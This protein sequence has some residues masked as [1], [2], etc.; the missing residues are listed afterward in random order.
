VERT[1]VIA[2]AGVNHNGSAKLALQLVEVAA[3]CGAD[4]VKFQSFSADK[5]VRRGAAKAAYQEQAT[6]GGDQHSMLKA[7][8]M[9]EALHRDL[10]DRCGEVGIEFMS[11][12]FDEEAAAFLVGLGMR[13]LKVPS[14]EITN[15]P[16]LRFL[17]AKDRPLILST[18]MATLAEI[19]QAVE[20]IRGE[21]ARLG[22][23]GA[24]AEVLTVLHCTSNYPAAADD[25]NLRAMQT[26]ALATG[27]PV[28]YSDHTRGIAVSTAAVALGATV[29]EKHF[30]LDTGL[31]GPDHQASLSPP[32]LAE[33]IAQIRVVERALG[34]PVKEP[35]AAELPIRSLVRRSVT[36]RRDLAAGAILG[37]DDVCLLRPG[38]GI[39]PRDLEA[40]RGRALRA[41][42]PAGTTLHWED[43]A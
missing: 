32:E 40:V 4:A 24:L 7:L 20:L 33:L 35:T 5:L 38:T 42:V 43:L 10:F 36:T 27:L 6:G 2:E 16:F 39:E 3:R 29:I 34:S 13:R 37:P 31:P 12:P 15:H 28:G 1:F 22:L 21:R 26:I 17:A 25:V 8:E 9:S 14:G 41:A 30:T 19:E 23:S 11:T 18:G